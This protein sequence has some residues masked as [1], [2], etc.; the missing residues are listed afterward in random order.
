VGELDI[1]VVGDLSAR[2][3]N[4]LPRGLMEEEEENGWYKDNS[5]AG[6]SR[7]SEDKVVNE[8]SRKL[9][10]FCEIVSLKILNGNRE[11]DV[12]GKM[13]FISNTDASVIDNILCSYDIGRCLRT[14]KVRD[15]TISDHNI[16][17]TVIKLEDSNKADKM[18]E[19]YS[20]QLEMYKWY[21]RKRRDFEQ[22][23]DIKSTEIFLLGVEY[24]VYRQEIESA[25]GCEMTC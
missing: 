6:S 4:L 25:G 19:Y 16:I 11:G 14:F 2:C 22:S 20:K 18:N 23:R 24:F 8:E 1:I 5:F 15:M 9:I 12:E 13:A 21:E 17:E 7:R 3:G 10:S